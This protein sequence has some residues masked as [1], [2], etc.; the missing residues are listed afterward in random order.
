MPS[1]FKFPRTTKLRHFIVGI[2][3][4]SGYS[5]VSQLSVYNSLQLEDNT[6]PQKL[7]AYKDN[8]HFNMERPSEY[9]SKTLHIKSINEDESSNSFEVLC[10][11]QGCMDEVAISTIRYKP[12]AMITVETVFGD[13]FL[14]AIRYTDR[15][16][17]TEKIIHMDDQYFKNYYLNIKLKLYS[18]LG[19]HFL[20]L[21]LVG[22]TLYPNKE[23]SK[24][25]HYRQTYVEATVL[26]IFYLVLY[27][28][29]TQLFEN[30]AMSR[31]EYYPVMALLLLCVLLAALYVSENIIIRFN[32]KTGNIE[33]LPS[34][35]IDA[36][37]EA[38]EKRARTNVNIALKTPDGIFRRRKF[39]E[40]PD[41]KG[42]CNDGDVMQVSDQKKANTM[43]SIENVIEFQGET[44]DPIHEK[45]EVSHLKDA[46]SVTQ[47]QFRSMDEIAND[48]DFNDFDPGVFELTNYSQKNHND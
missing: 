46:P 29:S 41:P 20:L 12:T 33:V 10:Y 28:I 36:V 24:N 13:E 15:Y 48:F 32:R 42:N 38:T 2:I 9:E 14:R 40:L 17:Q 11:K 3:L 35:S 4:L 16:N 6:F 26:I 5:H 47:K 34:S 39:D 45:R 7:V 23:F 37:G 8:L 31:I 27:R 44:I 22:Y 43:D 30:I 25:I 21:G 19:L 1:P 18:F